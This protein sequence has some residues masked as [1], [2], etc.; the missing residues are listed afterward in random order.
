MTL[1]ESRMRDF[2]ILDKTSTPDGYGG[3]SVVYKDG[4]PFKAAAIVLQSNEL[5]IAYQS[6]TKRIYA[7]FF[8]PTV[9]LEYNMRVKRMED[10]KVFRITATPETAQTAPFSAL[11]LLRTT[12]EVV[13]P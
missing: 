8:K 5:E 1:L 7:V 2:C 9:G 10:G 13:E 11:N 6:G 4:A 3:V 12:M